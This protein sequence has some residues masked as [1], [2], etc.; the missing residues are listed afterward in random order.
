MASS[1]PTPGP[2]PGPHPSPRGRRPVDVVALILG[3]L[4]RTANQ[5]DRLIGTIVQ[6][7]HGNLRGSLLSENA[8]PDPDRRYRQDSP[9]YWGAYI[10]VNRRHDPD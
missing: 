3:L 1:D 5:P 2:P 6:I 9:D 7:L 4:A 10:G 8:T